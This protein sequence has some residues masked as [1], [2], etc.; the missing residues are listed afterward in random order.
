MYSY[1]YNRELQVLYQKKDGKI[2]SSMM[3]PLSDLSEVEI[4]CWAHDLTTQEEKLDLDK[5][6]TTLKT[7]H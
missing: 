7:H 1:E 6:C 4:I 5:H 2:L 3:I